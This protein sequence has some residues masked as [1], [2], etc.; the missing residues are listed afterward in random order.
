LNWD[1]IWITIIEYGLGQSFRDL[2][3]T[4]EKWVKHI[5]G[6]LIGDELSGQILA[7]YYYKGVKWQEVEIKIGRNNH[8]RARVRI[9]CFRNGRRR[10]QASDRWQN[11]ERIRSDLKRD[12]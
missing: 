9:F 5:I 2:Y 4:L 8:R 6:S 1:D 12:T 11:H 7:N 10:S 3:R